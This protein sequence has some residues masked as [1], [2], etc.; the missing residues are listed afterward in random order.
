MKAILVLIFVLAAVFI[1]YRL[2]F[3][4]VRL[5]FAARHLQLSGH[6]FILLG[7]VLGPLFLDVLDAETQKGLAP[8]SS[9]LLGWIGFLFGFQFEARKLARMPSAE[10]ATA[11]LESLF[12]LT[13]VFAVSFLALRHLLG[14]DGMINVL[15]SLCLGSAAATT[16][17]PVVHL[18]AGQAR[19]GARTTVRLLRSISSVD[20][21]FALVAYAVVFLVRP[22]LRAMEAPLSVVAGETL[23]FLVV[24]T[25]LVT[26][27]LLL[28]NPRGDAP[29]VLLLVVGMI[30]LTSGLAATRG[31]S[32]LCTNFLLGLVLV[33]VAPVKER[34]YKVVESLEKPFYLL[35]LI[36]VGAA[37]AA[38][39]PLVY[40]GALGYWACRFLGKAGGGLLAQKTIPAL[41]DQ[42]RSMGLGLLGDGGLAVA[43]A[44]DFLSAFPGRHAAMISGMIVVSVVLNGFLAPTLAA[45]V[46]RRAA[47]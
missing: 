45:R 10:L 47:P 40:L 9:L 44:Y 21:I 29:A 39:E 36:F 2:T 27:F 1:G 16:A 8:L 7:L 6:E 31:F 28:F 19:S 46:F 24:F 32:T 18:A 3:R 26:M 34:I 5:P 20:G 12:T 23:I 43:V 25:A 4:G 17:Q 41:S 42:P 14:V 13:V 11:A 30:L 15:F 37:F 33:N 35:L 38:D 22:A